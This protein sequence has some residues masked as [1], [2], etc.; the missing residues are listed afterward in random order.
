MMSWSWTL[1]NIA[2]WS[3][4]LKAAYDLRA[5][6]TAQTATW[7]LLVW[8]VWFCLAM[9]LTMF[10]VTLFPG[11][12][13]LSVATGIVSALFMG[14]GMRSLLRDLSEGHD[15]AAGWRIEPAWA[16]RLLAL[17]AATWA[18]T[19]IAGVA[20]PERTIALAEMFRP[21]EGG[22]WF[23]L[24]AALVPVLLRS[25]PE[26]W[27]RRVFGL[28]RL[29]VAF[30]FA[31]AGA[32][33]PG[34]SSLGILAISPEIPMLLST[35][36]V[37]TLVTALYSMEM[38]LRNH[39]LAAAHS[40]L[41]EYERQL[42][43][44]E[45]LAAVGTLAAGAAHDFSNALAVILG[46]AEMALDDPTL[47]PR[48]REDIEQVRKAGQS[49]TSI[50]AGLLG[51]ARRTA[52]SGIKSLADA[53]VRPLAALERDLE[54]KGIRVV[55]E[56]DRADP[57]VE[58]VI[59]LGALSHVCLNLYMNGRDAMLPMGGGTLAVS[60]VSFP[61]EV[62]IQVRDTGTGV[63]Q[64]LRHRLFEPLM[65]TKGERGTGL[66]L[67]V[68]KRVLESAGGHL[69][70]ESEEGHGTTFVISLPVVHLDKADARTSGS[71]TQWAPLEEAA[72]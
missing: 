2:A 27:Q 25:K 1:L 20:A 57:S 40:Q 39:K 5:E 43:V 29:A 60:V 50:T 48:A 10:G 18:A 44:T 62:T 28:Q 47:S 67:S 9:E 8:A 3:V 6:H 7:S 66:G 32:V 35:L 58:V 31:G 64:A 56:I 26:P 72:P 21:L 41:H 45:K 30:G 4:G 16:L 34:I 59:D 12:S 65:T 15:T 52:D 13:L 23:V 51:V 55:T 53:V 70:F 24:S 63:P 36:F 11:L 38:R 71:F 33:L 61:S 49:A 17:A 46:H 69:S 37:L 42:S 14:A 19:W 54:H 22:I 68:S